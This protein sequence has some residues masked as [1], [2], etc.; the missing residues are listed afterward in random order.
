MPKCTICKKEK[1]QNNF[2]KN[3][4][5]KSGY[6]NRCK[7]CNNEHN[8]SVRFRRWGFSKDFDYN[9]IVKSLGEKQGFRCAICGEK[10]KLHLDHDHENIKIRGLL[11]SACNTG[12][13]FFK[14]DIQLLLKAIIYLRGTK[15]PSN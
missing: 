11:C 6:D 14:D 4:W 15:P 10:S 8:G 1:P 7:L 3:K 13:G 9:E 5:R 12:L 2:H